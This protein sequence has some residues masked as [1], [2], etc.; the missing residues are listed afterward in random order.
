MERARRRFDL[1]PPTRRASLA[2]VVHCLNDRM[3]WGPATMAN[4]DPELLRLEEVLRLARERLALI[5]QTVDDPAAIKAAQDLCAEAMTAV[6]ARRAMGRRE[7]RT[8]GLGEPRT[9]RRPGATLPIGAHYNE[10]PSIGAHMAKRELIKSH[11]DARY[12]DAHQKGRIKESDD[13]GRSLQADRRTKARTWRE[14]RPGR[15]GRPS[16]L[17]RQARPCFQPP[18]ALLR[19]RLGVRPGRSRGAR[20]SKFSS[21]G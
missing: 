19:G 9:A 6:A 3:Q 10:R 11:G 8:H 17:S 15:Q 5:I 12:I 16:P 4:P 13:V 14:V 20:P 21:L 1:A 7:L 18:A 2:T